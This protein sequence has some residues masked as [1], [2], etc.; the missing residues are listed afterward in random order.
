MLRTLPRILGLAPNY[1]K[2]GYVKPIS[3]GSSRLFSSKPEE[4][5]AKEASEQPASEQP[6]E[7]TDAS[8]DSKSEWQVKFESKDKECAKFK[9][10]Y[11]R[12]LADFRNLQKTTQQ[13]MKKAQQF[14][15]QKF[16][17]DLIESVDNFDLAVRALPQEKLEAS[18]QDIKEFYNG[19]TLVQ[20][21][22]EKTLAKHG[23]TKVNPINEKFDPNEHEA[24]FQIPQE[25]KEPGTIIHV[26]RTGFKLHERVLR[27]PK[28]GFV[29]DPSE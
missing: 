3:V 15:L 7:Q 9:E 16:A 4:S 28:V 1:V 17:K 12:S 6:A 23:I 5:E 27:A 24:L 11:Q 14:A 8:T 26:D 20:S 18:T 21:V 19:I 2:P 10:A 29:K 13:E 22:L 25:G